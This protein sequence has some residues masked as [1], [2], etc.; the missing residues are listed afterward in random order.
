MHQREGWLSHRLDSGLVGDDLGPMGLDSKALWLCLGARCLHS[1]PVGLA[2]K[3]VRLHLGSPWAL[4]WGLPFWPLLRR[5]ACG[6]KLWASIR[7]VAF[8]AGLL[9]LD[10]PVGRS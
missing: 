6:K 10:W 2:S 7:A 1:V 9:R 4:M 3:P 8:D 5:G